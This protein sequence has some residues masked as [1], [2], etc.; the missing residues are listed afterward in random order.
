MRNKQY[1]Q[2]AGSNVDTDA[3]CQIW[4]NTGAKLGENVMKPFQ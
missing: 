2:V 3:G 4:P 1:G